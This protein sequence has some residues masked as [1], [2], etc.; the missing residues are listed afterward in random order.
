[1]S[2][3]RA[4]LRERLVMGSVVPEPS[5]ARKQADATSA[6]GP[7][8]GSQTALP[9]CC[10]L[11]WEAEII[12][13]LV[14][15][16]DRPTTRARSPDLSPPNTITLGLVLHLNLGGPKHAGLPSEERGECS[17]APSAPARMSPAQGA[18]QVGPHPRALS[19]EPRQRR[20]KDRPHLW[21]AEAGVK[22]SRVQTSDPRPTEIAA[23]GHRGK[24]LG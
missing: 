13:G 18:D 22:V 23:R 19:E 2:P 9:P 8:P 10:V 14:P 20:V 6:E 3:G 5:A 16:G 24:A 11:T 7:L 21:R 17:P 4:Q 12:P 1:M 15:Q